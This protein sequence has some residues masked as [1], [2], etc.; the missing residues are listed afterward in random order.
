GNGRPERY[1]QQDGNQPDQQIINFQI[2]QI[3]IS[4]W[5]SGLCLFGQRLLSIKSQSVGH[6]A[7]Q[8]GAEQLQ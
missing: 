5:L 1:R 2:F 3:F 4:R 8:S 7:Q 6:F